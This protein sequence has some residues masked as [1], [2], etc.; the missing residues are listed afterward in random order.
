M[1]EIL[2]SIRQI[3]SEDS[4]AASGERT[5]GAPAAD[6]TVDGAEASAETSEPESFTASDTDFAMPP[7]EPEPEPV[8]EP[9]VSPAPLGQ[10][11]AEPRRPAEASNEYLPRR[12]PAADRPP[13]RG[14]EPRGLLSRDQGAAVSGAFGALAHTMLT[15]N[16]RTLEDVVEEMLRPMLKGWLDDNLPTL[17]ERLVKDEI[18]RVSRGRR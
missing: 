12:E 2:A 10:R 7:P 16:T 5:G 1:E 8:P 17:V 18:E 9:L 4:E 13:Q 14:S 6:V 15:Q 11:P 3:I